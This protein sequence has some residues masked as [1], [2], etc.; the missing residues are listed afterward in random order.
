MLSDAQ[1]AAR[2]GKL[3]ASAVACLMVGDTQKIYDLWRLLTG[4]PTY[5]EPDLSEIWAVQLGEATE[6]LNISWFERKNRMLVTR[7]GEVVVHPEYDWAA[8]TIDGWVEEHG[9]CIECKHVGGREPLEVVIE[10]Y[11]PQIGWQM[12]VTGANQCALSVIMGV[13]EPIVEFLDRDE[14][15][16]QEM[17][18]RGEQFMACVRARR[19]PVALEPVAAPVDASKIYS[20]EGNNTWADQAAEWLATRPF[21]DRCEQASKLLKAIVPDDAKKC[22]GHGVFI[23]RDRAGRLS[24]REAK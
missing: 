12:F 16:I 22:T 17:L 14:G 11:W 15:Y 10:R 6:Q 18:K 7:R 13:S 9:C 3:T 21:A 23:V 24:L 1:I 19:V 8:A 2:K 5:Q 20:M 4:D